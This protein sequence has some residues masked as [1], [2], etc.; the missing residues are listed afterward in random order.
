[1]KKLWK[2]D[3]KQ[4]LAFFPKTLIMPILRE[5]EEGWVGKRPFL[6]RWTWNERFE[7]IKYKKKEVSKKRYNCLLLLRVAL[8][9]SLLNEE[10]RWDSRDGINVIS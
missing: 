9:A 6:Q 3:K 7:E 5:I 4:M 1:M 10:M 8:D 2:I